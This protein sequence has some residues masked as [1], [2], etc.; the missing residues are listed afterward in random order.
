MIRSLARMALVSMKT[1]PPLSSTNDA[2]TD[3]ASPA[4]GIVQCSQ[5]SVSTQ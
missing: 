3:P 5:R 1:P 4:C 2:T